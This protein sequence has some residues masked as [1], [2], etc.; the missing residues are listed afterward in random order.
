MKSLAVT[1]NLLRMG[2]SPRGPQR[3]PLPSWCTRV[4]TFTLLLFSALLC[5]SL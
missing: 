5:F 2:R 4:V 1:G 3:G